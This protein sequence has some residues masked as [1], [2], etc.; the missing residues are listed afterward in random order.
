[1]EID[2]APKP[3]NLDAQY[4][5][6]QLSYATLQQEHQSFSVQHE[7]LVSKS[8]TQHKKI[9]DL[10]NENAEMKRLLEKHTA[11][12][13]ELGDS[14]YRIMQ[15]H[16]ACKKVK[17]QLQDLAH[18]WKAESEK[19]TELD[20]MCTKLRQEL[21]RALKNQTPDRPL[22]RV[23]EVQAPAAVEATTMSDMEYSDDE[24]TPDNLIPYTWIQC[25]ANAASP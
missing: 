12:Y 3:P 6:L 13:Q 10:E 15:E 4:T 19:N 24:P 18:R 23:E 5:E 20:S 14:Y 22:P 1:M 2:I 25:L 11:G 8:E 16:E 9:N 21:K 17:E 7:I